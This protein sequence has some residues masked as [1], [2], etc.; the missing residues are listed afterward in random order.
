MSSAT[1]V[2]TRI[3]EGDVAGVIGAHQPRHAQ[4]R[5]RVEHLGIEEI[6]V[7]AAVEHIDLL[8]AL[9]RAHVELVVLDEEIAALDEF[10]AE[11]VGQEGMLVI[12]RVEPAG[13]QQRDGRLLA[14]GGRD[15]TQRGE[16]RIGIIFDRRDAVLG[17]KI[18]HQP[19]HDFA[20]L[21]HV[22]DA[23]G[24]ADIVFENIEI[25]F[26]GAHDIDAGDHG[27]KYRAAPGARPSPA[28]TPNC[29]G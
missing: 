17:E 15:R 23:G 5:I 11:L 24:R 28:G 14:A 1:P 12:G 9:G 4:H 16:Q 8:R 29:R 20:I 3:G 25:V 13:R 27:R 18:R 19:H 26:A 22:G 6:V 2:P 21:Q 10:D 7:D